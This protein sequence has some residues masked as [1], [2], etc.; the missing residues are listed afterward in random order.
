MSSQEERKRLEHLFVRHRFTPNPLLD[1]H[2]LVNQS[3]VRR[4]VDIAEVGKDEVVAD[5]GAGLGDI[6]LELARRGCSVWA[7]EKDARLVSILRKVAQHPL[8]KIVHGDFLRIKLPNYDKVVANPPFA[9]VEAILTKMIRLPHPVDMTL[10][11]PEPL[12]N[13]LSAPAGS[14]RETLLSLKSRLMYVVETRDRVGRSNFFP[15]TEHDAYIVRLKPKEPVGEE[16][17]TLEFLR[18]RDKKTRNALREA[19]QKTM[20]LTRRQARSITKSRLRRQLLEKRVGRL[21]LEEVKLVRELLAHTC[22]AG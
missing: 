12:A 22:A 2:F 11:L 8:I 15:E 17:L 19:L 9:I 14:V 13:R 4:L 5:V 10:I 6:S 16:L 3:V 1:Q 20:H 18:Q 21:T 7:V